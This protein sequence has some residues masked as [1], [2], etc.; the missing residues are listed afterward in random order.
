MS[1]RLAVAECPLFAR[2]RSS[3]SRSNREAVGREAELQH[4]NA[5]GVELHHG[6]RLDSGRQ[7]GADC[8]RRRDDLRDGEVEVD[9]RLEVNLIASPVMSASPIKVVQ[10]L[11]GGELP[12][13]DTIEEANELIGA[14]VTGLWNRLTRHQDRASPF[15]LMRVDTA[16]TRE[17]L[18]ALALM[19][20]QELGGFI[21]GLFGREEVVDL[22]SRAHRGLDELGQMRALFEAA[23]RLA[24]DD[25]KQP[26]DKG[27][28]PTLRRVHEM[29]KIAHEIHAVV[30]ACARARR[31]MMA[32]MPTPRPTV[33]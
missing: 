25:T 30:L 13:F 3:D 27:V 20:R 16:S 5:R 26:T 2:S 17:G 14:L 19:R 22:P 21:E 1:F 7:H 33:H 10:D 24:E 31:Q 8:V 28:E 15:R 11:W 12:P 29:T 32:R 18:A 6:R 4:R 23:V 9:V